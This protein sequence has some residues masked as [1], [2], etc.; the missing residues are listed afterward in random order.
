MEAA[1]EQVIEDIRKNG[2]T[3]EELD[4]ARAGLLAEYV[5]SSDSI[6]RMARQYGWRLSTGLSIEDI[7]DWPNRIK[8]VTVDDCLKVAREYLVDENS[9]TGILK[10][11]QE[12]TS[13]I[14]EKPLP[15]A[16]NDK[17]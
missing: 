1:I 13:H 4:R 16:S 10:P 14:E 9:V 7:E 11:S 17:S 2:V 3:Q 5:Y 6:S 8:A 15:A 12:Q